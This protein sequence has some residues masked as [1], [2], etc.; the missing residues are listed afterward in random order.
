VLLKRNDPVTTLVKIRTTKLMRF[1]A[2]FKKLS[3]WLVDKESFLRCESP[4]FSPVRAPDNSAAP[5]RLPLLWGNGLY[6]SL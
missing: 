1:S 5:R 3:R 2:I 6:R 4:V